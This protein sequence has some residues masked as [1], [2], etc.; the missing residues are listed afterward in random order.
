MS[1]PGNNIST[2]YRA[3]S[4]TDGKFVFFR[5]NTRVL[6]PVVLGGN[7]LW[8]TYARN[9]TRCAQHVVHRYRDDAYTFLRSTHTKG[10]GIRKT[11]RAREGRHLVVAQC[12]RLEGWNVQRPEILE[13]LLVRYGH[14]EPVQTTP[15]FV[16]VIFVKFDSYFGRRVIPL[17][18]YVLGII[19]YLNSEH[20]RTRCKIRRFRTYLYSCSIILKHALD[21]YRPTAADNT[22]RDNTPTLSVN[23]KLPYPLY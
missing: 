8:R 9:S 12:D 22:L 23:L 7:T 2:L 17:R 13:I 10:G 21:R 20:A 11:W 1:R 18:R 3:R 6:T 19:F 15:L 14:D 5:P 4:I 16:F